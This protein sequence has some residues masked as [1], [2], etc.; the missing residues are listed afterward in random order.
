MVPSIGIEWTWIYVV[1]ISSNR[2]PSF[3]KCGYDIFWRIYI[4]HTLMAR[5]HYMLMGHSKKRLF[6]FIQLNAIFQ[7]IAP[8]AIKD[9]VPFHPQ[10]FH[11]SRSN[12][13]NVYNKHILFG[14]PFSQWMSS[15]FVS[16]TRILA[17]FALSALTLFII[18][19]IMFYSYRMD[20][21]LCR[22][23]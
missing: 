13:F 15:I 5:Y 3:S 19:I 17:V 8:M 21:T 12:G 7:N 6:V 16:P 4:T 14:I 9:G 20:I 23:Q 18:V 1:H 2:H 11:L 10:V 22:A